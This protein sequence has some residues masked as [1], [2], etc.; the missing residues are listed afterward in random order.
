[1]KWITITE[2]VTAHGEVVQYASPKEW[3]VLKTTR[4]KH[5]SEELTK[6]YIVK[7]VERLPWKQLKLF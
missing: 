2:Y 1:M 3:K 4:T 6:I 5:E 7:V